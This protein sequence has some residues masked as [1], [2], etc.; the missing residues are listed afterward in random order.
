MTQTYKNKVRFFSDK[1]IIIES[2]EFKNKN[3]SK[4]IK[5]NILR[6]I[7]KTNLPF[8]NLRSKKVVIN[9]KE[10]DKDDIFFA[11]KGKKNDA[12]K[13]LKEVH[14]KKAS[15]AVVEKGSKKFG[16]TKQL[17]VKNTL[18]F[19]TE[20]AKRFRETLNTKIIAITGSCGK[21]SL[22]DML[23][24]TLNKHYKTTY[25][26]KSFNNKYGVPLSLFNID[27]K[28]KFG[29]LEAGMDK[30][31]EI[32]FLSNI[33]KPDV[34][35]ITNISY[36]HIKNF[37]NISEIA[38]AKGEIINNIRSGGYLVLNADDK[39]YNYH[40]KLAFKRRLKFSHFLK[41][42]KYNCKY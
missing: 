29:V 37:N 24:H 13:F 15:I 9:S 16:Y 21:T 1:E 5:I 35:V 41:N 25:S 2:I 19:L 3:L 18:K 31:G 26:K 8:K 20:C 17:K 30:K 32:D 33:M 39:F 23:G 12:H 42:K 6:E 34:G 40:K 7:S 11:I 22:K 28:D 10:I 36:A 14:K 4:D 38:S 27:Q